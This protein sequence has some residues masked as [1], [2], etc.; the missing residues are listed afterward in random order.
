MPAAEPH[1]RHMTPSTPTFLDSL[2]A[3]EREGL[4][5]A[6]HLRHWAAGDV[7]FREGDAAGSAIVILGGLV[8]IHKRT[9]RAARN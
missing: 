1:L 4:Q 3:T 7:L 5:A 9:V 8:K 6:G 2:T